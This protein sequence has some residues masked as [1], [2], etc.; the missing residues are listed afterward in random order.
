MFTH[1]VI[2]ALT[3]VLH[4]LAFVLVALHSL[5]R[6][7]NA[8]STILWIFAA[9]SFPVAGPLLYLCFGVDRIPDRGFEKFLTDKTLLTVRATTKETA[10]F[11]Y[12][13]NP[14]AAPNDSYLQRNMDRILDALL[15]DH[16]VHPG[17]RITPLVGG[18]E[19][20]VEMLAAI[21]AAKK[22]I[23]LQSY[24]IERDSIS[25]EFMDAL[26]ERAAAGV[27]IRLLYDRFGSTRA[28][29]SGFFRK[30][31]R[32]ENVH[33]EGWTQANPFKRQFQ[34]NLRNHRKALVIDGKKAFFGG[35]N[36]HAENTAS[37]PNGPIRDYHFCVEGPMVQELQYSFLRDWHFITH[38]DPAGLLTEELFPQSDQA[39]KVTARLINSGPSTEKDVAIEAF[40]NAITLAEKQIL[41]VTPYFVPPADILRALHSAALRGV[42]VRLIVPQKNNHRYA[43]FASRALYEELLL[44]G[45]RIYERHPPFMHAKALVVDGELSLIGTAN[46]DNR[47]LSLNYETSVVV[48]SENFA[49]TMKNLIHEDIDSSTEIALTEWRRRPAYRRLL[50][51]L[52]LLMAPVL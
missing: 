26:A 21:R 4:I 6:K 33:I 1:P 38:E 17:N 8:S 35:I 40:F 44:A 28:H 2:L 43:G 29:L 34:I 5:Q 51:N 15:S 48:Y 45:V 25:R 52:A 23:H 7:R 13:H 10:P 9:W 36:I 19:A 46:L 12:W 39:G 37:N 27:Q 50:E 22:H 20:Y 16:P 14:V 42:D 3:S 32:H 24:I 49:D 30:Y 31:G 11:A 47:S 41:A 18:D